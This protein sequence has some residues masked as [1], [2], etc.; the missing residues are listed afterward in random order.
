MKVL[1]FIFPHSLILI[2]FLPLQIKINGTFEETSS[3]ISYGNN[4]VFIQDFGGKIQVSEELKSVTLLGNTWKAFELK[5]PYHVTVNTTLKFDFTVFDETKGH[6]ICVEDDLLE[7]PFVGKNVRCLMVAGT[8]YTEWKHVMKENIAY[9]RTAVQNPDPA[10]NSLGQASRAVDGNMNTFSNTG[11]PQETNTTGSFDPQKTE[12]YVELDPGFVVTEVK[13][14]NRMDSFTDRLKKYTLFVK[15]NDAAE[16]VVFTQDFEEKESPDDGIIHF[17]NFVIDQ[18]KLSAN[19]ELLVGISLNNQG[20]YEGFP[21]M[22]GE[23]IVR[24]KPL[25]G[26]TKTFDFRVANLFPESNSKINYIALIQDNDNSPFFGRSTFSNIELYEGTDSV[27]VVDPLV[28]QRIKIE[29]HFLFSD[30]SHNLS[31]YDRKTM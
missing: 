24:G 1:H 10:N 28:S 22:I 16:T 18:D 7:D 23:F 27:D 3:A 29:I 4:D 25:L 30:F 8:Q 9:E 26:E 31:L 2:Q 14:T 11:L 19:D 21:H 15:K 20:S 12:F 5:T 6:A 17:K 13:I